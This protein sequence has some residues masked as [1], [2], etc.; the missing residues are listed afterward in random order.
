MARRNFRQRELA[1]SQGRELEQQIR[2]LAESQWR[3]PVVAIYLDYPAPTYEIPGR[4]KYGAVPLAE[5]RRVRRFFGHVFGGVVGGLF[6]AVVAALGGSWS[7]HESKKRGGRVAG[8][9]NAQALALVDATRSA[10]GPSW[11]VYSARSAGDP[12]DYSPS[13]VA[14][15]AT[16]PLLEPGDNS[17][18][19]FV[20]QAVK[21]HTPLIS[22]EAQRLTWPDGS[23][24]EYSV[25][26]LV[27][28]LLARSLL[29]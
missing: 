15:I 10:G 13:H 14:V 16:G 21:P 29:R 22:P 9:Q 1:E 11:L 8:P 26:D 28:P 20:W 19:K 12:M 6:M 27:T 24:F 4:D 3:E 2:A 5:K 7:G 18:P 25:G 23:V 17:P